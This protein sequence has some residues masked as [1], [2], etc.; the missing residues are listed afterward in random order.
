VDFYGDF[1]NESHGRVA[2][3]FAGTCKVIGFQKASHYSHGLAMLWSGGWGFSPTDR[4]TTRPSNPNRPQ[5][6][7][8]PWR[9]CLC[10][11]ACAWADVCAF[12][13]FAHVEWN[14]DIYL[15][16]LIIMVY[17]IFLIFLICLNCLT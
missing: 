9:H 7:M 14:H 12:V 8:V 17:L 4:K 6:P 5:F 2:I 16:C 13:F 3:A 11:H 10:V 15:M 1:E